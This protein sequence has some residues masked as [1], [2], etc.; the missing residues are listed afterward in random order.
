[1]TRA[2]FDTEDGRL[3]AAEAA[4]R[5][6]AHFEISSGH[7]APRDWTKDGDPYAGAYSHL[8]AVGFT[9]LGCRM[10]ALPFIRAYRAA[11]P[12]TEDTEG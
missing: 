6:V 3:A 4:G 8:A 12:A 2:T 7:T 5:A 9:R 10:Y 1:M 11:F